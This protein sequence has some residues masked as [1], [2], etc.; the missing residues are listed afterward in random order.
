M[1]YINK[2]L[3]FCVA[4]QVVFKG[5]SGAILRG[6][7]SGA[8]SVQL[9][10]SNA[11]LF[12]EAADLDNQLDSFLRSWAGGHRK[13]D[14][15]EIANIAK[16]QTGSIQISSEDLQD[17]LRLIQSI[18]RQLSAIIASGG[19]SASGTVASPVSSTVSNAVPASSAIETVVPPVSDTVSNTG[20]VSS[21]SASSNEQ[22]TDTGTNPAVTIVSALTPSPFLTNSGAGNSEPLTTAYATSVMTT[23]QCK[24]TVTRTYTTYVYEE[25]PSAVPRAVRAVVEDDDDIGGPDPSPTHD[26]EQDDEWEPWVEFDGTTGDEDGSDVGFTTRDTWTSLGLTRRA[27]GGVSSHAEAL[28]TRDDGSP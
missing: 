5:A 20:P 6:R 23:T 4:L 9:S 24:T 11:D 8:D 1:H 28:F 7:T 2:I 18:E 25:S 16:R 13:P 26:L 17:L 14:I 19:S 15:V 21:P 22:S 3:H 27:P 12:T 10:P